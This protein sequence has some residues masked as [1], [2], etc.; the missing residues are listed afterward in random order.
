MRGRDGTILEVFE[1]AEGGITAAHSHPKVHELRD[2][3]SV[4]CDYVPLRGL[5]EAADMF[6]S[7]S[8]VDLGPSN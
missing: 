5:P 2:R 3:L 1:W 8:T 7:F 4:T 6:A